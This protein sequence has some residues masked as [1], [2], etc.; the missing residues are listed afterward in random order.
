MAKQQEAEH[1]VAERDRAK[2]CATA[3]EQCVGCA[4]LYIPYRKAGYAVPRF[5]ALSPPVLRVS[6]A[7]AVSSTL[8]A[9]S[10]VFVSAASG[11]QLDDKLCVALLG[12]VALQRFRLFVSA[13]RPMPAKLAGVLQHRHLPLL[14]SPVRILL[15]LLQPLS[16][17]LVLQ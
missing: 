11:A 4:A 2:R 9:L 14:A 12:R 7:S 1:E 16:D 6:L 10:A 3:R 8:A 17:V 5:S 15:A 13:G